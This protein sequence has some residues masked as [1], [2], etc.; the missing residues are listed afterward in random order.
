MFPAVLI[1]LVI[2]LVIVGVIL[3]ALSQFPM[4]PTIA[5]IIRVVII[6]VVA[7]WL[8]YFLLGLAGG[9]IPYPARR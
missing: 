4:D 6:V 3:W 1:Q 5:R 7:I 8:L 2:C 9:P